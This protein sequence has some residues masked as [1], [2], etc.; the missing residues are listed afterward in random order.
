[1]TCFRTENIDKIDS[2]PLVKILESKVVS[3]IRENWE[4]PNFV[5]DKVMKEVEEILNFDVG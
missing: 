1:M 3:E 2:V 5:S 4:D